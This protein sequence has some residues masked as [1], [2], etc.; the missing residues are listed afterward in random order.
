[1][2]T[3]ISQLYHSRLILLN[4]LQRRGYN[5]DDYEHFSFN[6]IRIL[7]TNN[8]LDM[9]LTNPST[10]KKVYIKYHITTKLRPTHVYDYIDDLY[11]LE[12]V[13]S[14]DDELIIITKDKI[15]ETLVKLMDKI[16]INDHIFFM[17]FNI[18]QL[19][20]NILD[21]AL[22]PPHRILSKGEAEAVAKKYNISKKSQWP[23]ISRFDPVAMA[24]GLH[25]KEVCEILR[26]SKTAIETK[27]Y[28]LCY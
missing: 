28:R 19:S 27:Y 26:P 25:P 13:L 1:M 12:E 4:Q 2:S 24:I 6:E 10:N 14:A 16:Y 21:H 18:K 5:V 15:P 23:E 20:F 7:V 3:L 11:N 22:V 17:I 8:Q 9:L